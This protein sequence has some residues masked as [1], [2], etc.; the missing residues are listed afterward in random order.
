MNAFPLDVYSRPWQ[1]SFCASNHRTVR[2]VFENHFVQLNKC[3]I[4]GLKNERTSDTQLFFGPTRIT[5]EV[6]VDKVFSNFCRTVDQGGIKGLMFKEKS[7]FFVGNVACV[8]W[9]ADAPFL[10]E[11]YH[12]SDAYVT[13]GNKLL[14]I[15]SSFDGTELKYK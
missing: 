6:N 14:A 10:S 3:D 2:K 5:G 9:V 1:A 4:Q 11:P 13:C 15:V 12:G 8:S 7:S